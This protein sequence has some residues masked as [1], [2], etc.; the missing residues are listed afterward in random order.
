MKKYNNISSYLAYITII[1]VV[2]FIIYIFQLNYYKSSAIEVEPELLFHVIQP[3]T[4][5]GT[6]TCSVTEIYKNGLICKHNVI[7]KK[8][9]GHNLQVTNNIIAYDAI[10]NKLEYT[11]VRT[12]KFIYQPNHGNNLFRITQS[13]IDDK[14]VSSSYGY[15]TG[16][17]NNSIAFKLS[18]S[19]H[20]SGNDYTNIYNTITRTDDETIDTNFT[21]LSFL[22]LNELVMD[23]KYTMVSNN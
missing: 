3:G 10:T 2:C 12:I 19:W 21:H 15:A 14:L 7:V 5:T 8:D 18:G 20:I 6:S 17:T 23:E 16:K 13:Y 11:G 4:Y 22:G 1:V 9:V